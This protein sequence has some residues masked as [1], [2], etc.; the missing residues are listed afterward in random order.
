MPKPDTVHELKEPLFDPYLK[1]GNTCIFEDLSMNLPAEASIAGMTLTFEL[2]AT[3]KR[4][5]PIYLKDRNGKVLKEWPS[6]P[7]LT[8][9]REVALQ[10]IV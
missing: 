2:P 1:Y 4:G 3:P 6:I 10:H 7:S 5:N 8:E 9:I